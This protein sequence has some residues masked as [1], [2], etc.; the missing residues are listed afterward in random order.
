[1]IHQ[2]IGHCN[3]RRSATM[4]VWPRMML[5]RQASLKVRPVL[6][7]HHNPWRCFSST[8]D[9]S[10]L[11]NIGISA[12]IDRYEE[13]SSYD[14][15]AGFLLHFPGKQWQDHLDGTN[16]L[17]HWPYQFYPR[18]PRQRRSW[19]Q[20]GLDGSRTGE[21]H[22]NSVRGNLLQVERLAYQHYRYT[23]YVY[24]LLLVGSSRLVA[25]NCLHP[26]PSLLTKLSPI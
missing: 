24:F 7:K 17:L 4:T 16:S 2:L 25:S 23:R 22:Y 12:H 13:S 20:D 18:C 3:P 26:A 19:R 8:D 10:R 11:R 1:M 6:L 21:G 14:F 9:G 5:L 15:A